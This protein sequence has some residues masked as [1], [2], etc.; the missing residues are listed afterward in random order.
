[1]GLK[2]RFLTMVETV[3]QFPVSPFRSLRR[4][5]DSHHIEEAHI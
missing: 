3:D 5:E 4:L 1:M 2:D